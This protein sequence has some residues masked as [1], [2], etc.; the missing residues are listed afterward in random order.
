MQMMVDG[1]VDLPVIVAIL[2]EDIPLEHQLGL[3]KTT[4]D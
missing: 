1:S 4:Q 2:F 3:S